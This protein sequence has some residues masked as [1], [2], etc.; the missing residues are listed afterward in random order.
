MSKRQLK[1]LVI[2]SRQRW[3]SHLAIKDPQRSL[4][5]AQLDAL[6][7]QIAR[8]L[9]ELGVEKG[10][11][12]GI[13]HDKSVEAVAVMQG[14]LRLGAAY[15][16]LDPLSPTARIR[17]IIADCAMRVVA[18]TATRAEKVLTGDLAEVGCLLIDGARPGA[19]AWAELAARSH[20]DYPSPDVTDHDL[21]YILYTSG[22]TGE[23][24]GVCIS[25]LNALSFIDWAT[26]ELEAKDTDRFSNHA[27]FHFDL[28]VLDLYCAF[29]SGASVHL[30]PDAASYVPRALVELIVSE[31]I[32]IWYS[33]PTVLIMM[34]E[35]G[36]LL[37]VQDLPVRVFAF[38]GEPFPIKSLRK[39]FERWAYPAVRYLN[40]YGPTET[41]V[42]TYHEVKA[43]EPDRIKPVPIGAAC[44]GDEVWAEAT[45][46]KRARI[47]EEGELVVVGPTV[48]LGYWGRRAQGGEPYRTGDRV[49]LL[50]AAGI[51]EYVGRLDDM[52][53]VHGYRIEL[54]DIEVAIAQHPSVHEVA[55]VVTGEGMSA[56][57]VAFVAP[58]TGT[59]PPA[60]LELKRHCSERLPRYMIVDDLIVLPSLHRTR[61]GKVDRIRLR[62]EASAA[63][64]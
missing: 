39:L 51:Y 54:G 57:L 50:D 30:I 11:R 36:G 58:P 20:A 55:M 14:A 41:N 44:S 9:A 6:A 13:W 62:A 8:A 23:P 25:Q 21:A 60:L 34:M 16:P 61:N 48:L 5:Y 12:V 3:P 35:T 49:K 43:I 64:K 27:P 53:K 29:A 45:D 32:T 52:V 28:T 63:R 18:T 1:D 38:A 22:S 26:R 31:K 40:L 7:N 4:T 17:T 19:I 42:C 46:G 24:K 15:V 37:E 56:R 47:G 33:V 10:D 59:P 2:A